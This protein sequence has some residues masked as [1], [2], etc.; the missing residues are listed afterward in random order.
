[1][2]ATEALDT[3]VSPGCPPVSQ[4]SDHCGDGQGAAVAGDGEGV[5]LWPLEVSAFVWSVRCSL[6]AAS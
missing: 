6:V 2:S 1:M 4:G 3:S 5:L